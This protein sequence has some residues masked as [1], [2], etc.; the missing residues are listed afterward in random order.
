MGVVYHTLVLWPRLCYDA[1][2]AY[3]ARYEYLIE[4]IYFLQI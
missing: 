3:K 4:T 2:D 1:G